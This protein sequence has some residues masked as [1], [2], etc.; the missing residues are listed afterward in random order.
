[1]Q[2]TKTTLAAALLPLALLGG[3]TSTVTAS[4]S[5]PASAQAASS[6]AAAGADTEVLAQSAQ[7][8]AAAKTYVTE[9]TTQ[10]AGQTYKSTMYTDATDPAKRKMRLVTGAGGQQLEVVTIGADTYMKMGAGDTWLKASAAQSEQ[11]GAVDPG[12]LLAQSRQ[13]VKNFTLAGD[14][15]V[16]GVATK[17]YTMVLD[18][19]AMSKLGGGKSAVG[20][21]PYE[22]WLDDQ[23][24]PRQFVLKY[25][26]SAG[27]ISTKGTM[28][29]YG[30]PV[31]IQAPD[32][33]KVKS[34]G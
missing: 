4:Q 25:S 30:E 5:A 12:A 18:G 9:M 26:S 17:H 16:D 19:A 20:D 21:I 23:L 22:I 32:P 10:L 8:V 14:E 15:T 33:S 28:S 31:D 34:M 6:S 11:A 7:A 13:Y 27:D 2:I 29:K 24:R 3:C 1:M